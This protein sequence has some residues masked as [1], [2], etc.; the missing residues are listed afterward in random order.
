MKTE[1][2]L[3]PWSER[4]VPRVVST[5]TKRLEVMARAATSV[6][7]CQV[8]TWDQQHLARIYVVENPEF[9]SHP[10]LEAVTKANHMAYLTTSKPLFR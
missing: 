4:N 6:L 2:D 1:P 10:L 9:R 7:A 5:C 3:S 8:D